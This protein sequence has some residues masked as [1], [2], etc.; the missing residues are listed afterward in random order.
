MA[1]NQVIGSDGK[2]EGIVQTLSNGPIPK[3]ETHH[4]TGEGDGQI[5]KVML[6]PRQVAP[7][8]GDATAA[9]RQERAPAEPPRLFQVIESKSVLDQVSGTRTMLRAGK[10]ISTQHYDVRA[11]QRQGVKLKEVT[12]LGE[13]E[14]LK[15]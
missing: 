6:D 15:V 5:E 8:V 3:I 11:L 2:P 4:T 7:V 12:D 10:E 13:H 14:P 1:R 9:G